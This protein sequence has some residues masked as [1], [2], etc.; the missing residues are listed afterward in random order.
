MAS[1][2]IADPLFAAVADDGASWVVTREE[3]VTPLLLT[4]WHRNPREQHQEEEDTDVAQEPVKLLS[5]VK[6]PE[7]GAKGCFGGLFFG[8]F[9][10]W[11]RDCGIA[12]SPA[13]L[14]HA[15]VMNA[16]KVIKEHPDEFRFL[17]TKRKG[18]E[19]LVVS[20]LSPET[21]NPSGFVKLLEEK[22]VNKELVSI[23]TSVDELLPSA[24]SEEGGVPFGEVM[25]S[26]MLD[27]ASPYFDYSCSFCGLSAIELLGAAD[28]WTALLAKV[29]ALNRIL[30]GVEIKWYGS[31][32][33]FLSKAEAR[34]A[35]LRDIVS[36]A[37]GEMSPEEKHEFV[38]GC[39]S[40][41]SRCGSGH[42]Y[43]AKGWIFDFANTTLLGM[44]GSQTTYFAWD[45]LET[46]RMFYQ[47]Y[48]LDHGTFVKDGSGTKILH[49]AFGKAV[50]EVFD[51]DLFAT[52]AMRT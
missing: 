10:A 6:G 31:L 34:I 1:V 48:A 38:S 42:P 20:A 7:G 37:H 46:G 4:G 44:I 23:L 11:R 33:T 12:L 51:R 43:S 32:S 21:I 39:F 13:I 30:G 15:I 27:M 28:E 35:K 17:F 49:M 41:K 22:I 26:T 5:Q 18:K 24:P 9:H 25:C 45:S 2:V 8:V 19:T 40:L 36:G 14:L 3:E 52:L 50:Y 29:Q 47:A 16:V